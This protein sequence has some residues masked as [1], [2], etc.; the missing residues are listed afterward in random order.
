MDRLSQVRPPNRARDAGFEEAAPRATAAQPDSFRL[1]EELR[2]TIDSLADA[3]VVVGLDYRVQ[4]ANAA[5]RALYDRY[6]DPIGRPCY[7]AFGRD[8]PCQPPDRACPMLA[9]LAKGEPVRVTHSHDDIQGRSRYL[10]ITAS[11]IRE[12]SGEITR[13]VE[14]IRD[15]TEE[16][17]RDRSLA[18]HY[19]QLAILNSVA[20]KVS[21]S[22]DLKDILDQAL[23]EVLR[24]TGVDVGA[25]FLRKETVGSLELATQ[26]GLSPEAARLAQ[27]L[28]ML[29]SS[30][31]GA[32]VLEKVVVVPDLAHYRGRRA[33]SLRRERLRTLVH[34]PLLARGAALG[35][36]CVGTRCLHD[37]DAKEQELLQAIAGQIAIAI[38]NARLYAEVARKE[39]L[40]G[41]LLRRVI[42]AQE[43]ERKRI[44]RE[45]HDETS[46]ALTA[47]LFAADEA[48]ESGT[49]GEVRATLERMQQL[50]RHTLDG[51][52]QLIFDLRPSMLDHLG[53]VPALRWFA[54]SRLE[55]AGIRLSI[56]E[57]PC[58]RRLAAEAETALFRAVQEAINNIAR[59][60]MARNVAL[61]FTFGN[62]TA[63][64][65]VEDDG[66]GFDTLE[67]PLS[68]DSCRGLGLLGMHERISLLG[69]TVEITSA[70][71]CGTQVRISLPLS[72]QDV[73]DGC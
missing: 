49:S 6:V 19:Q 66:I 61:R 50:A 5:A 52:H 9:V 34:V 57:G 37:F 64:V 22:L 68:P 12:A 56:E 11:P 25:I 47:L 72:G 14:L 15:V 69:G 53:L 36:M 40:R 54:T 70:P 38:E 18:R 30:C 59:H 2:T 7:L 58:T 71:R 46:Q 4:Q 23:D 67:V 31:G 65:T 51:V 73:R 24:L 43:E 10:E 60:A 27:Q 20:A 63:L 3:L 33:A 28:G 32:L 1:H 35:S 42:T 62:D 41:E 8:A 16:R 17:E 45:L 39:H 44:A 55:P 21:Q 26:R 29:D 48:L 13:I